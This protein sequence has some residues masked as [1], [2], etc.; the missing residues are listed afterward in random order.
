MEAWPIVV[1]TKPMLEKGKL[2]IQLML[3][4]SR[5]TLYVYTARTTMVTMISI[6]IMIVART[7]AVA[8]TEVGVM[9]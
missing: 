3:V 8:I 5:R 6:P 9:G 7:T 1:E 4:P 2:H